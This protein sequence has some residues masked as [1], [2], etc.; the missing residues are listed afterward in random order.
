MYSENKGKYGALYNKIL[1]ESEKMPIDNQLPVPKKLLDKTEDVKDFFRNSNYKL[2]GGVQRFES[3]PTIQNAHQAQSDLGKIIRD[4]DSKINAGKQ[5]SSGEQNAQKAARDLQKR[6]RGMM[7]QH[8]V[9]GGREDLAK[10]YAQ[11]TDGYAKDVAPLKSKSMAKYNSGEGTTKAIGKELLGNP[12]F[13]ESELAK[14]LP[15]YG[16]KKAIHDV[17]PWAKTMGAAGVVPALSMMG[18]PIPY[19]IRKLLGG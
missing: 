18:V 13:A 9:K 11:V 17:P 6:I 15:G 16:V 19:Y 7:Q 2:K 5:L 3:N 12:Q 10:Q 4:F 1:K 8:F 14:Q